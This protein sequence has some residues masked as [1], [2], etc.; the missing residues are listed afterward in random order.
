MSY[1]SGTSG[2]RLPHVHGS[3]PGDDFSYQTRMVVYNFLGLVPSTPVQSEDAQTPD[4]PSRVRSGDFPE[5][6]QLGESG[7]HEDQLRDR[8]VEQASWKDNLRD[9]PRVSL[10]DRL[11]ESVAQH[12]ISTALGRE[13]KVV[14]GYI[15]NN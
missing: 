15:N 6:I 3:Q 13:I 4:S 7:D 1:I 11:N 14:A 9:L 10:I 8:A 2:R 5:R 12:E